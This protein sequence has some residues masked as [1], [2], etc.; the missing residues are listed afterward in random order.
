MRAG[1]SSKRYA[2]AAFQLAQE[3][4]KL[5]EWS[6]GLVKLGELADDQGFRLI[7]ESPRV[8]FSAKRDTLQQQLTGQLVDVFNLAQLLVSRNRVDAIPGLVQ[9]FTRLADEARGVKHARVITAVPL[10]PTA[11]DDVARQL[12]AFTGRQVVVNDE[13]DAS[14]IGG[15][16]VRIGDTLIDGSVKGRLEALHRQLA[17]AL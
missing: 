14:I 6:R 13:V 16:V 4:G 9:E 1:G 2:Q 17:G 10:T 3:Q 12:A 5:E 8:P 7:M 15:L 11:K